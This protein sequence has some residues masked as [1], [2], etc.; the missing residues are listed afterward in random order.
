VDHATQMAL[1][2]RILAHMDAGTTDRGRMSLTR[3]G[4]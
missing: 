3:R 2:R 4:M 1:I